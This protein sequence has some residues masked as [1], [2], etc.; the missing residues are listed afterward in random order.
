MHLALIK[1]ILWIVASTVLVG[2]TVGGVVASL[3]SND[4]PATT[5]SN[6][7]PLYGSNGK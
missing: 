7:V 5:T 2:S 4:R 1:P 6:T 3:S